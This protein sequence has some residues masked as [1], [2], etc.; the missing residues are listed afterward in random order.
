M[1]TINWEEWATKWHKINSDLEVKQRNRKRKEM[2][3]EMIMFFIRFKADFLRGPVF[4]VNKNPLIFV[5]F[6]AENVEL[7]DIPE[8]FLW[9][10][11][12]D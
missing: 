5:Y 1:F 2:Q 6:D 11:F 3:E 8:I 4:K 9:G 7:E 10:M 12:Q